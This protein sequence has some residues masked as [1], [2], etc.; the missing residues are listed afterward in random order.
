MSQ[1]PMAQNLRLIEGGEER[2]NLGSELH[3]VVYRSM[4]ADDRVFNVGAP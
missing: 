4:R 1:E 2:D 3:A